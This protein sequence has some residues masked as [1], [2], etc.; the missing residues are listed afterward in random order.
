MSII[1]IV[2]KILNLIAHQK[3]AEGYGNFAEAK[4]YSDRAQ[5]LRKKHGITQEILN[6]TYNQPERNFEFVF[7]H[8]HKY[9]R[10]RRIIWQEEMT[11]PI[12]NFYNCQMAIRVGNNL[13]VIIGEKA[14]SVVQVY[15]S[16]HKEAEKS[17]DSFM[18]LNYSLLPSSSKA[19]R[20]KLRQSFLLGFAEGVQSRL[21]Y[22]KNLEAEIAGLEE[23]IRRH[24]T[25]YK[26][27]KQIKQSP[28]PKSLGGKTET[29]EQQTETSG[30]DCVALIKTE[31]IVIREDQ[32]L[33]APQNQPK[34]KPPGESQIKEISPQAYLTGVQTAYNCQL[35]EIIKKEIDAL[36][37]RT[38]ELKAEVRA[39][40]EQKRKANWE[41]DFLS[42][43][44]FYGG[45]VTIRTTTY[46]PGFNWGND[47]DG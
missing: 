35:P 20:R 12:C 28:Q 27:T 6:E 36:I 25:E 46:Q 37:R 13:K 5:A 38:E 44:L 19:L 22:Y 23:Q 2:K 40:E 3:S 31:R 10:R 42:R 4:L 18:Q 16:L 8:N 15:L 29:A 39:Q 45:V 9:F 43:G 34:A 47:N 24:E 41:A 11:K 14:Q 21:Y 7:D 17:A 1:K 32:T 30:N 33:R 26:P